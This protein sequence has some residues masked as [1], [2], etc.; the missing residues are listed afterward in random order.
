MASA[1]PAS[2]P[3]EQRLEAAR[4]G[5]QEALGPLLEGYRPYL[6]LVANRQLP[7]DLRPKV[8]ASD[9]VQDTFLEAQRDFAQFHGHTEDELRAWLARVLLNNLANITRQYRAT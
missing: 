4:N 6:L 8:G 9:L 3:W 2:A 7:P 1:L 5:L